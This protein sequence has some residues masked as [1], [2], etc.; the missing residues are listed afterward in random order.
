MQDSY[1]ISTANQ[2]S[3]LQALRVKTRMCTDWNKQQ[4]DGY[5]M[6][7]SNQPSQPQPLSM[8]MCTA[9]GILPPNS[10]QVDST[11][12]MDILKGITPL[13]VLG[14][15]LHIII[16]HIL[17]LQKCFRTHSVEVF[18]W[19]FCSIDLVVKLLC[20][21]VLCVCVVQVG[22]V[23]CNTPK[24]ANILNMTVHNL[25]MLKPFHHYNVL[26]HFYSYVQYTLELLVWL[27]AIFKH[28]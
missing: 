24:S 6:S 1:N 4:A 25:K 9:L 11:H 7:T 18:P 19:P 2:P 26:L 15:I 3:H 23:H 16:T 21:D 13:R 5:R 22:Q 8:K 17:P 28:V 12:C 27:H 14:W 20:H 10:D